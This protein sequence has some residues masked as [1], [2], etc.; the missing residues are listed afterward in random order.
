VTTAQASPPVN[1]HIIQA[2]RQPSL[3]GQDSDRIQLSLREQRRPGPQLPPTRTA[4]LATSN[5]R[6]SANAR[7]SD[8]DTTLSLLMEAMQAERTTRKLRT[9]QPSSSSD[10]PSA[11]SESDLP[12][13]Q[14]F[15]T[16]GAPN[17]TANSSNPRTQ[18]TTSATNFVN[19]DDIDQFEQDNDYDESLLSSVM[20]ESIISES[21]MTAI[22][23]HGS[24]LQ[25]NLST[26][27]LTKESLSSL[28][29]GSA[30]TS[31]RAK[32][33]SMH[34]A[35]PDQRSTASVKSV[36]PSAKSRGSTTSR[37]QAIQE[38][39]V[40]VLDHA[41]SHVSFHHFAVPPPSNSDTAM[42]ELTR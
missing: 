31:S 11:E 18:L 35:R 2:R 26:S 33:P 4:S 40:R 38:G 27:L 23:E 7:R 22:R 32:S 36:T 24:K 13:T 28:S 9:H 34:S 30:T 12:F 14:N 8:D 21:P 15:F 20:S 29:K 39:R 16:P 17:R 25:P 3:H 6:D 19:S 10:L 5:T 42:A 41:T 37:S 1:R